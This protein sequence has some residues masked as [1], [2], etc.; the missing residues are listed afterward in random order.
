MKHRGYVFESNGRW[1][2]RITQRDST[3]NRRNI[4]RTANSK[5]EAELLLREITKQLE[6][7]GVK[8]I[9]SLKM[10]FVDLADYYEKHY[11]IPAKFIDNQK[12]EGLR[13][14][15][16]VVCFL[17][18][19]RLHFGKKKLRDI[20]HGDLSAY[21]TNRLQTPTQYDKPRTITTVN[22]ELSCLRRV[23]NVAVQQNWILKTPFL[24]GDPLILTACERRREKILTLDE[25]TRLLE[26]CSDTKRLHLKPLII[27][28]LDTGCRKGEMLKLVWRDVDLQNRVI[29]IK[30]ENTKT[31]KTRTVGIATVLQ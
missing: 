3:G 20:T 26:A 6:N 11:A 8:G 23:F 17:N 9:D 1:F 16:R 2:A 4:K 18:N 29:T 28:L 27:A 31:L 15:K 13:D 25:E 22:R 10:T 12:I 14:Y 30:A 7:E 21:R 24:C 5:R 19:F